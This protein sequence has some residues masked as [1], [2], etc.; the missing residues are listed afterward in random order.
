MTIRN[1]A[2]FP[3]FVNTIKLSVKFAKKF[4]ICYNSA[5]LDGG[6]YEGIE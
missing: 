3:D 2:Y 1:I 4:F 5:Q 6:Y